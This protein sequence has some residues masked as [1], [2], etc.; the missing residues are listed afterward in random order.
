NGRTA[1]SAEW[2]DRAPLLSFAQTDMAFK[3]DVLV[4]GNYHGFNIYRLTEAKAPT[5]L[6]SVVCPGGQG[7]VSIVG[8]LLIM[9]AEETRGRVD[10]GRQGVSEDVSRD[11][12]RGLRIFDISDL[13]SAR[14]V[15][16]VQ[17]C[18]GSHTHSVVFEDE[19]RIVVYNS[20]IAGVRK[21]E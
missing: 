18:R 5:L 6:S 8:N 14:Q 13:A 21:G 2:S 20:G 12:F 1:D 15:G 9:S 17:T 16:Q 10:C 7:D 19:D 11:R 3:G 4:T